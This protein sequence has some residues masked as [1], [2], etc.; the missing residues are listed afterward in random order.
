MDLRAYYKRVREI[1]SELPGPFVVVVS[2]ES[3]DGGKGG[4]LTEVARFTAAK[5]IADGRARV[6]SSQEANDFHK[7]NRVAKEAADEAAEITRM[8]FVAV[9][10]RQKKKGP[11]E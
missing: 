7:R 6:A 8:K 11:R 4:V 3:S 5:Q 2:I 10:P 1:E 9:S